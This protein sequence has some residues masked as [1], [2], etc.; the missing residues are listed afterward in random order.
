MSKYKVFDML[1]PIMVG[2]SSSHTAG[3]A[4]IG[5]IARRLMGNSKIKH[6]ACYLH[7]SFKDTYK[8][9]GTDRAIV[10][11]LLDFDPKDERLPEALKIADD[12]GI[13][14]EFIPADLGEDVHPNTVKLV[15]TTQKEI[16]Y[17]IMGS[18]LGGGKVAIVEVDGIK[19][20]FTGDYPILI[21]R[22]QDKPGVIA[23]ITTLLYEKHINIGTMNVSR[24]KVDGMAMMY[25]ETDSTIDQETL[26]KVKE[27]DEISRVVL[28][29]KF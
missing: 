9:H 4:R 23:R 17:E 15:I 2:P 5:R 12:L 6:I 26:D 18:S 24:E 10:A 1:G 16:A 22:H 7:G 11:G 13:T 14:Y 27:I 8:G 29:N 25:I 21:T 28:L 19:V 3:A 20:H